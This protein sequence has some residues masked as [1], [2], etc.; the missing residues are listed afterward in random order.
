MK[1][2]LEYALVAQHVGRVFEANIVTS[3]GCVE[4]YKTD[5]DR[6]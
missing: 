4:G 1:R 2:E 6:E 5:R 3:H